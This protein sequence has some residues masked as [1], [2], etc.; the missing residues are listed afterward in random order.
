MGDRQRDDGALRRYA[1]QI[2]QQ[3]P[4]NKE[5]ALALLRYIRELVDWE[6]D[7]GGPRVLPFRP[8]G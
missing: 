6:H 3:L 1:I 8:A 5:D 4:E 2:A 7:D